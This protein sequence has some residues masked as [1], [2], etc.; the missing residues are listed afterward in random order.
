MFKLSEHVSHVFA[1][2]KYYVLNIP[3]VEDRLYLTILN[4]VDNTCN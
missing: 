1:F 3:T 2:M 4:I